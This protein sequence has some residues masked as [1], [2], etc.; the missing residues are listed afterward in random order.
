MH[1]NYKNILNSAWEYEI[2]KTFRLMYID[3]IP[4]SNHEIDGN[5]FKTVLLLFEMAY[6]C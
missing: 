1:K 3:D 6:E 2:L 4:T 5:M